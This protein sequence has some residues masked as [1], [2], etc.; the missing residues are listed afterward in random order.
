MPGI[1]WS[2]A[3]KRRTE[4]EYLRILQQWPVP[5]EQFRFPTVKGETFVL[6]CGS[7]SAPPLVLFH[8]GMS[9]ASMWMSQV[10]AWASHF[11]I[12]CIDTIGD[13]GFS[14]A[15]RPS[16]ATDEHARW[17]DDVW[18]SLKVTRASVVGWSLG[19]WL[20]L[21]YAA[22][23]S[24][25]VSS[26]VCLAPAGI[27]RMRLDTVVRLLCLM[28]LG[29]WGRRKGFSMSMGF[30]SPI[31]EDLHDFVDFS[32]RSAAR[33]RS[34]LP[35]LFTAQMLGALRMPVMVVLGERDVFFDSVRSRRRLETQ[36]PGSEIHYMMGVGHGL[37]GY[38]ELI[39]KFL[40]NRHDT[41][42]IR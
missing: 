16:F 24:D 4:E 20:G 15:S 30:S 21:D 37:F 36:V 5:A 11:R 32:L 40:L 29:P 33:P 19:G 23:R 7:P 9:N 17:L 6:A 3:G 18:L 42:G 14:A 28:A 1:Y 8:G 22:R 27:V 35:G 38:R 12:Y 2:S 10:S 13:P 41:I 26:L 34:K 25:R 31:P 39:L